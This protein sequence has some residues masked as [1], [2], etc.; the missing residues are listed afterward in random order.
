[1]YW[2][3]T[4]TL[5]PATVNVVI[6]TPGPVL[7]RE[8]IC[9]V[10]Q[11]ICEM[12]KALKAY[13]APGLPE[14]PELLFSTQAMPLFAPLAEMTGLPFK[15]PNDTGAVATAVWLIEALLTLNSFIAAEL[16]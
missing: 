2:P 15:L 4:K 13:S 16:A 5:P 10:F 14:L 3:P 6:L 7:T 12:F 1:M 9:V 11:S 8:P